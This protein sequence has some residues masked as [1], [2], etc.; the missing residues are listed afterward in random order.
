MEL[1]INADVATGTVV[2]VTK[3][4]HKID[5]AGSTK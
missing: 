5:V 4:V 1:I 3:L 2:A